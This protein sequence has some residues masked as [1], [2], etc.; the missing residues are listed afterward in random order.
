MPV[1]VELDPDKRH[2]IYIISDPVTIDDL[3]AAYEQEREYRDSIPYTLHSLVDMSKLRSI[4]PRWLTAKAGPG[5]THPRSGEMVFCGLSTSLKI[6][7]QTI[8][9]ITNY[10]RMKFFESRDQAEAYMTKLI[11]KGESQPYRPIP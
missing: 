5:L 3:L 11:A 1:L 9:R 2:L 6:I 8:T 10:Q 4:P 7:V